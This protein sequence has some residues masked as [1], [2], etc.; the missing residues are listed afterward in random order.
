[1]RHHARIV[2]PQQGDVWVSASIGPSGELMTLW[3]AEADQRA[4]T[5]VT[6]AQGASFP[7]ARASRPT[8]ARVTVHSPEMAV[9]A[10]IPHLRL[11]HPTVQPLPDGRVLAVGARCEWR[12]EGA[13]RNAIVYS[14][15]GEV[16]AEQ[17]FGDA[18]GHVQTTRNGEIWVGYFDEG[19]FGAYGWGE[20][21]SAPPIGER[22]LLRFSAGLALEWQYPELAEEVW[23]HLSDCYALNVDGD[24]AWTCSFG[25][26]PV[27]RIRDGGVTGWY[28]DVR[29]A[30]ALLV[31]EPR[32]ALYGGYGPDCDRL[33]SGVLED[34]RFRVAGEYR[35]V[36]PDGREVP[37][38]ALVFGRGPDLHV[39]VEDDWFRLSLDDIPG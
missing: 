8:A 17:T 14:S 32:V 19:I 27:L 36:L 12:P 16:L 11:A 20:E 38:T 3:S 18:I 7:D 5:P 6:S 26:F 30:G 28:N 37:Q 23:G 35:L 21:D 4:L 1:M 39:L 2:P 31:G 29:G 22:G 15:T 25:D 33:V 9:V 10:W 13:D 34:D 24:T